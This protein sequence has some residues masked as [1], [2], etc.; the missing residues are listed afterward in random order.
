MNKLFPVFVV[1]LLSVIL[2]SCN[3]LL[4]P[5]PKPRTPEEIKKS[6]VKIR[7]NKGQGTGFVVGVSDNRA[8]ILT[9]SHVIEG[10][11][12]PSVTFFDGQKFKVNT[13]Y[14]EGIE[15]NGL[16]L[17]LVEGK[18]PLDAIP[19]YLVKKRNLKRGEKV[20]SIGF[21]AGGVPWSY[22]TLTYSGQ[23]YRKLS[24]LGN[25]I[26]VGSSGSPIMKKEQVIAIANSTT[27]HVFAISSICARE[28]LQGAKNG[29][30]ILNEMEKWDVTSWHS[31]YED[32]LKKVQQKPM[33]RVA[34]V[35]SNTNYPITSSL[36]NPAPK[37]K[38]T[39]EKLNF[40]VTDITDTNRQTMM[41][42]VRTFFNTL[43]KNTIA[44]FYYFGYGFQHQG[45][46]Y[47]VPIT[48]TTTNQFPFVDSFESIKNDLI[49]VEDIFTQMQRIDTKMNII[50]LDAF[51]SDSFF[52]KIFPVSK[53]GAMVPIANSG[54]IFSSNEVVTN[55]GLIN[56][57]FLEKFQLHSILAHGLEVKEISKKIRHLNSKQIFSQVGS[58][59]N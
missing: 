33:R 9:V 13:L 22:D 40:K 19:L 32:H 41:A 10:D 29:E 38:N 39:L 4:K 12:N 25:G 55:E 53:L 17:L 45:E 5:E 56:N 2:V 54:I 14:N 30:F 15:E 36:V 1:L 42:S 20:Y 24:F 50:I 18:I 47:L 35:I 37:I 11:P 51:H 49:K 57:S 3:V 26:E 46:N 31:A 34:L 16:A 23:E 48:L 6:V 52:H 21:P 43:S 44:L 28:F 59:L 27:K 8:Y 7:S 58:A